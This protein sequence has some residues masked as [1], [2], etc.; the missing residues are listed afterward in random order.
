MGRKPEETRRNLAVL[1]RNRQAVTERDWPKRL[2]GVALK[3]QR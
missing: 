1:G 3:V 2:T